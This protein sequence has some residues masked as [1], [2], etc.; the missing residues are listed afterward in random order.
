MNKVS[1]KVVYK[2]CNETVGRINL[3]SGRLRGSILNDQ[4]DIFEMDAFLFPD[5]M[6]RG[7]HKYLIDS[8]S[9]AWRSISFSKTFENPLLWGL[10]ADS[11][12]GMCLGFAF[13]QEDVLHSVSYVES[14]GLLDLRDRPPKDDPDYN[15]FFVRLFT[16]KHA[17]WSYEEEARV[18]FEPLPER[19][20]GVHGYEPFS[21]GMKLVEVILGARWPHDPRE[22][23][24]W[25]DKNGYSHVELKVAAPSKQEFRIIASGIAR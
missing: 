14:R 2:F 5:D 6:Q 18:L 3:E 4:N 10:Y 17:G 20:E 1:P 12:K 24:S 9:A 11:N 16:T 22:F 25:L 15:N 23:R 7:A 8:K 19:L 21:E 13:E